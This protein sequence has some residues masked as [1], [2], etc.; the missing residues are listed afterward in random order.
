MVTPNP[1]PGQ[2]PCDQAH[3]EGE[4]KTLFSG[5]GPLNLELNLARRGASIGD[6][7]GRILSRRQVSL[8][9]GCASAARDCLL[10]AGDGPD[11]QEGFFPRRNRL[12][13]RGVRR[14]VGEI[15]FAGEKAQE[16]SPLLRAV[17]ADSATQHRITGLECVED[18]ALGDRAVYFQRH[19]AVDVRQ[20]S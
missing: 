18:G 1:R 12:G 8:I 3:L 4:K 20:S 17:L 10:A 11:N 19:F 6:G 13:Q 15:F 14:L 9:S 16:R 2:V 5:H 7:H